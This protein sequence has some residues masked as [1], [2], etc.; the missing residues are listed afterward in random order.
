[1]DDID[2]DILDVDLAER[3]RKGDRDAAVELWTRHYHAVLLGA[4]RVTW[5]SRD[6]EEIASDAFSG[7]LLALSTGAGPRTSVRAYLMT[8]VRNLAASRARRPSSGEVITDDIAM[9][10]HGIPDS[11][12][13]MSELELVRV[14]FADLPQRWQIVLWR[15]AVD[16]DSN[17]EVGQAMGLSANG[18][19]A[20]AKRA[21]RGFRLAYL[22][23][24]ISDRGVE[25]TCKPFVDGLADLTVSDA[26]APPEL[27]D[28]VSTCA[29]CAKRIDELRAVNL[30]LAGVVA[31]AV[32]GLFPSKL[33]L[34][35]LA[36]E[37]ALSAGAHASTMTT[38]TKGALGSS[39]QWAAGVATV[40]GVAL[41]IVIASRPE[42]DI[43]PSAGSPTTPTPP[44]SATAPPH[45]TTAQPPPV[46]TS[47]PPPRTTASTAVP[48]PT[49][50][51]TPR[52]ATTTS[53]PPTPSTSATVPP[54]GPMMVDLSIAGQPSDTGVAVEA[55]AKGTVGSLRLT[56]QVPP[57]VT[58]LAGG[59]DWG[60]CSQA[61]D[62][63]TCTSAHTDSE[64]WSGTIHTDWAPGANGT[65]SATVQGKYAN[66]SS[67]TGS[68]SATWP[69]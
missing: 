63:I 36:G 34:G 16:K 30:N 12:S 35:G 42:A 46:T 68:V 66:G 64:R 61:G 9:F 17:I 39:A 40:A 1:M 45:P 50:R 19:A 8:S 55:S 47:G 54:M 38:A 4:R 44:P 59:G 41:A 27:L 67:A 58:L 26:D 49:S 18:V 53:R 11:S 24:H 5:Q 51:P 56:L 62:R 21:R 14:A 43:A 25:A 32:F 2:D 6:A 52:T 65:V 57:G 22:R 48:P 7:M 13:R 69:P 29:S 28:H 20:L 33:L 60:S 23:A 37:T 15:T 3:V 10:D 31:P